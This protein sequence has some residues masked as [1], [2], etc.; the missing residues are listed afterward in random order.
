MANSMDMVFFDAGRACGPKVPAGF[1]HITTVDKAERQME[2]FCEQQ[3]Q[4][5]LDVDRGNTARRSKRAKRK[6][7]LLERTRERIEALDGYRK[8]LS[9]HML[10]GT[11][12][13]KQV[14]NRLFEE[15]P[16][17][18]PQPSWVYFIRSTRFVKIGVAINPNQR[19][20][21]IQVGNP[22]PSRIVGLVPGGREQERRFHKEFKHFRRAGEWFWWHRGIEQRLEERCLLRWL[23]RETGKAQL[24]ALERQKLQ[25]KRLSSA[26]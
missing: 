8:A 10:F 18:I 14:T 22:H 1:E 12:G 24:K 20:S 6:Y 21:D 9:T 15:L 4:L 3:H 19:L 23:M 7:R 11:L 26:S 5:W 13:N 25:W 17:I 2:A 16:K